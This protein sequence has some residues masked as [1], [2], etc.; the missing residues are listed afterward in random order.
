MYV[1]CSCCCAAAAD[2]EQC[3]PLGSIVVLRPRLIVPY[4]HISLIAG[5]RTNVYYS[6]VV[7]V[8]L[9]ILLYDDAGKNG[10]FK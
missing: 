8:V 9:L 2:V 3:L 10:T 1:T 5:I 4:P 7:L 6:T